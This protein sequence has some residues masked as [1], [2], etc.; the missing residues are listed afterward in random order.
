MKTF[1]RERLWTSSL[2]NDHSVYVWGDA[3]MLLPGVRTVLSFAS[4][5]LPKQVPYEAPARTRSALAIRLFKRK[6]LP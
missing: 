6:L 2:G 3:S 1:W 4:T 5:S